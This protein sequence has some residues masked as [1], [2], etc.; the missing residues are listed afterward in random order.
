MTRRYHVP[1]RGQIDIP[2]TYTLINGKGRYPNGPAVPLA[3]VK[4]KHR[5][6]YRFR[7]IAMS[8]DPSFTFSVDGHNLT[9]IEADGEN[10]TPVVVDSLQIFAGQRYSAVL[11]ASQ[12]VNNYWIRAN[13]APG[14]PGFDG[15]RNSAILRYV[16]APAVDPTTSQSQS[17]N[18]LKETNLH[19]LTNPAAPGEPVIGG[20]DI[21][22]TFNLNF[23]FNILKFTINGAAFTPPTVPV[24]LQILSGAQSAQDLLPSGS[25][26]TLPPNKVIEINIPGLP[27]ALVGPMSSRWCLLSNELSPN[28]I[29]N[30]ILSIFMVYVR[31]DC[32]F[33]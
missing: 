8:C 12:P 23:D 3:V 13:P 22:L 9:T 14:M 27:A 10:T 5:K 7:I 31:Q 18:L 32:V 17:T 28:E 19:P 6:R 24:L 2:P 25:L 11:N 16:G 4:V 1:A 33:I 30:S 21:V 29:C 26:Y 15:G 20:A